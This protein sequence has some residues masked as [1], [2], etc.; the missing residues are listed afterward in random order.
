MKSASLLCR[1]TVRSLILDLSLSLSVTARVVG[2]PGRLC[3]PQATSNSDSCC[4]CCAAVAS[5]QPCVQKTNQP[6]AGTE[7]SLWATLPPLLP[8]LSLSLLS[9]PCSLLFALSAFRPG[10]GLR[11]WL[12]QRLRWLQPA[13]LTLWRRVSAAT[14]AATAVAAAAAAAA[15]KQT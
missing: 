11:L 7:F 15:T 14:P 10:G 12:S 9:N 13:L 5:M 2:N 3:R 4:C 1:P 8:L 6:S